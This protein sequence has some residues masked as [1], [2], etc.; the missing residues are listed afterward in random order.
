MEILNIVYKYPHQTAFL[1]H[2]T[3][4][5]ERNICFEWKML[6]MLNMKVTQKYKISLKYVNYCQNFDVY[7]VLMLTRYF[8]K[9]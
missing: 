7:P 1:S 9:N 3:R 6:I 5:Q 4:V 8:H 2:L